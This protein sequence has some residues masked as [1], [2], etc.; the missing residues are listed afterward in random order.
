MKTLF[1]IGIFLLCMFSQGFS[2]VAINNDGSSPDGSAMLDIQSNAKGMLAPR[3]TMLGRN[4]IA[5]PATGLTVFQTDG[6]PGLYYNSGTPLLP[7]WVMVGSNAGQWHDN[8]FSIY[9]DQGSVGIGTTNPMSLLQVKF[10]NY[11]SSYLGYSNI[12][13]NYFYHS[14]LPAY[15][16]QQATIYAYRDRSAANDGTDTGSQEPILQ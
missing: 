5:S 4:A 11:S 3:M 15:G 12:Y 14:E 8:G 13:G 7:S 1:I 9:Y 16:D 6:I 10:G 2:Q